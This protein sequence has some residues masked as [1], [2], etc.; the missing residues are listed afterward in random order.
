MSESATNIILA[1]I[2]ALGGGTLTAVIQGFWNR[3]K[4]KADAIRVNT[5]T[6]A[7]D[8]KNRAAIEDFYSGLLGKREDLAEKIY[9]RL[10]N[11]EEELS[12]E[13]TERLRLKA[14]NEKLIM[15]LHA[16]GLEP[17]T[18]EPNETGSAK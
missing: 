18:N 9:E 17:L 16:A 8:V 14:Q 11:L 10:L 12:E 15:Q 5:E 1:L 6:L 3:R 7:V 4:N 13:Q 2:S